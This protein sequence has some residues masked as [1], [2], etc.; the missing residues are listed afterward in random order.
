M[1]ENEYEESEVKHESRNFQ[2]DSLLENQW[3]SERSP[4]KIISTFVE[5]CGRDLTHQ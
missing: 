1:K 5:T 2:N 3:A 4:K